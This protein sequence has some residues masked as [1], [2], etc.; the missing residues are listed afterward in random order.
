MLS[1]EIHQRPVGQGGLCEGALSAG[2]RPLRWVYDCGS[3]QSVP[4]AREAAKAPRTLDLLFLSHLDADHVNGIDLLLAHASAVE[5]VLPYLNDHERLLVLAQAVAGGRLTGQLLDF[6]DDAAGWLQQRGVQRVTFMGGPDE[7]LEADLPTPDLPRGG[8]SGGEGSLKPFWNEEPAAIAGAAA[9]VTLAR[10]GDFI[11]IASAAGTQADWVF[12]PFVHPPSK[13]L[14]AAFQAEIAASFPGQS[15]AEIV[16][17]IW[18]ASGRERLHLCYDALWADHNLVSMS[19]YAGPAV[20]S[21][22]WRLNITMH[23][24]ATYGEH[25][26]PGWLSTGDADLSGLRRRQA[27]MRFYR[28]VQQQVAVLV[29]PHHGA[30]TSWNAD[31]LTGFTHLKVGCA[32]AGPN[33][34]G[35]PHAK[36]E[37]DVWGHI[38][39]R[40]WQVSD[41]P[42][43]LLTLSARIA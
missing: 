29:V 13:P 42:S 1:A 9:G 35:H 43:S 20:G 2:G 34:Y 33:G 16:S 38:G 10:C 41:A 23:R 36:V 17:A 6:M 11:G 27:F 22:A 30:A 25:R 19:L 37:E 40:F 14:V 8:V 24:S 32:A 15:A 28:Q 31:V 21:D 4:L 26:S 18:D 12:L 3:N 7:G 39:A 5:V